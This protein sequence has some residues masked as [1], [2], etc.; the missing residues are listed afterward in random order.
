VALFDPKSF[1]EDVTKTKRRE[2]V[3]NKEQKIVLDNTSSVSVALSNQGAVMEH[4]YEIEYKGRI[5]RCKTAEAATRLLHVIEQED[6]AKDALPW[7]PHDFTEFTTRIQWRQRRLLAK[8]LEHGS[9]T[10]LSS[11]KTRSFAH[12]SGNQALAG[13]LSGIT[14]VAMSLDIAPERVYLRTTRFKQGKP[15]HYYRVASGFLRAAAEHDWPSG[16]D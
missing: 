4:E 12:V 5:I 10:W 2:P 11:E 7:T 13:V 16:D 9:T 3:S 15:E 1:S 6:V 8:L 14:K